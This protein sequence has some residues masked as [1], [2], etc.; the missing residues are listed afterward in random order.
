[1][2]THTITINLPQGGG[3]EYNIPAQ[4]VEQM[5]HPRLAEQ[6]DKLNTAKTT[7]DNATTA[8]FK[9]G[10]PHTGKTRDA[11]TEANESLH[12]TLL[13]TVDLAAA[14]SGTAKQHAVEQYRLNASRFERA[15]QAMLAALAECQ[16]HANMH[17]AIQ[18]NPATLGLDRT[19]R[20]PL[21]GHV[22]ALTS[23]VEQLTLRPITD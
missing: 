6:L 4:A 9:A 5:H 21:V 1:M 23:Q 19:T 10:R 7:A 2:Q 15:R 14:T 16:A 20:D 17:A 12:G 18:N 11:L 8:W 3:T 13:D 22:Q